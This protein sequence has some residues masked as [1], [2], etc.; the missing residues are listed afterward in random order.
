MLEQQ[1]EGL[2][3][4][5]FN[6]PT[7]PTEQKHIRTRLGGQ[8][9]QPLAREK[10]SPDKREIF[11]SLQ[12]TVNRDQ[13]KAMAQTAGLVKDLEWTKRLISLTQYGNHRLAWGSQ[14]AADLLKARV[15]FNSQ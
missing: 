7:Q 10:N 14:A 6:M 12:C 15:P 9:G 13:P 1:F 5:L 8:V 2:F 11:Q 4:N 3:M